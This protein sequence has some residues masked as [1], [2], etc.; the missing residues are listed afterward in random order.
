M[1]EG[2]KKKKMTNAEADGEPSAMRAFGDLGKVS[3]A[4]IRETEEPQLAEELLVFFVGFVKLLSEVDVT[5]P[6]SVILFERKEWKRM[7]E[8]EES[9]KIFGKEEKSDHELGTSAIGDCTRCEARGR[10]GSFFF[11]FFFSFVFF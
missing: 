5:V 9:L 11:F 6:H 7:C 2:K 8:E 1:S 3:V 4:R 10:S